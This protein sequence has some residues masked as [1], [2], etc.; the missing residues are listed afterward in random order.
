MKRE[1][2]IL[3]KLDIAGRICT[4]NLCGKEDIY[5]DQEAPGVSDDPVPLLIL[6]P[7]KA[8]FAFHVLH[9]LS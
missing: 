7:E 5:Y 6:L 3:N 4:N 8:Q 2:S 9:F 1:T